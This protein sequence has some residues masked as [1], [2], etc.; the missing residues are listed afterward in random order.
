MLKGE[1]AVL[2]VELQF[3]VHV[4]GN[5]GGRGSGFQRQGPRQFSRKRVFRQN[6][7]FERGPDQQQEN[8]RQKLQH[9]PS[10]PTCVDATG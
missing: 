8:G 9:D 2:V 3:V 10:R 1:F 7:R 5:V 4:V 6:L